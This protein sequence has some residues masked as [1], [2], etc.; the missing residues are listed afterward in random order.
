MYIFY[1]LTQMLTRN[2]ESGYVIFIHTNFM[3]SENIYFILFFRNTNK[4]CC[5]D[6]TKHEKRKIPDLAMLKGIF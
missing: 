3:A 5:N 2:L 1:F 4:F 6:T